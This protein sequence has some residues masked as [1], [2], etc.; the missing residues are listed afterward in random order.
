MTNATKSKCHRNKFQRYLIQNKKALFQ[1][2]AS[3]NIRSSSLKIMVGEY[4]RNW[5]KSLLAQVMTCRL[6]GTKPLPERMITYFS[7]LLV[8]IQTRSF[9]KY[10]RK[11]RLP[12]VSHFVQPTRCSTMATHPG[13]QCIQTDLD[14][15]IT[16]SLKYW[17]IKLLVFKEIIL[18][19]F[20]NSTV[21]VCSYMTKSQPS[22]NN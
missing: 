22:F 10:I 20:V 7:E 8:R 19:A 1:E 18:R 14:L 13:H 21:S 12:N 17:D 6:F 15:F 3:E 5:T 16:Y 11:W 2:N 9:D 4:V